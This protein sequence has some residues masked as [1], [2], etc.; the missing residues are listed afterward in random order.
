LPNTWPPIYV[1]LPNQKT[2]ADAFEAYVRNLIDKPWIIGHHWFL[3]ADQPAEGRFDGEN[4]NFGLVSEQ[5][6]PYAPL[7]ERSAK[8]L[9]VIYKRLP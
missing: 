4:N 5:D 1:T 8:M 9:N 6:V 2:R 3:F 7:V